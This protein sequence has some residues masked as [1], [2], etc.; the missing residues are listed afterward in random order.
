MLAGAGIGGTLTPAF[1][2]DEL[3]SH[4]RQLRNTAINGAAFKTG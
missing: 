2:E 1:P 3:R 4:R